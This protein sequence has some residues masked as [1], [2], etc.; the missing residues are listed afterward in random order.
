MS[1]TEP[2]EQV[3]NSDKRFR[4]LIAG[5]RFGKTHLAI[6]EL[7]K[8]ARIPDRE[9]VYIAPSYRQAK[10]IVWK[11]LKEKLGR[12][13]WIQKVNE[14][15]LTI[16][17]V[18]NSIIRLRS[19]DNYDSIRGMGI[20]MAVF[21]E[22]ADIAPET[23]TEVVRPAL[24]DREG[25]A[26]FIGT[27]KGISNWAKDLY[28]A[29]QMNKKDWASWQFTTIQGG[30]VKAEEIEAARQDLDDKTFRQEYEASFETYSGIIYYNFGPRVTT[31]ERPQL[32][33]KTE[34]HIGC[35]FNVDPMSAVIGV[36]TEKGMVVFDEIEIYGSNTQ[37]MCDEINARYGEY[38]RIAYPDAS[39]GYG[40]TTGTTDLRIMK[41]NGIDIRA[42][43]RNPAV[44][45]RINSVNAAF[46]NNRG[47]TRLWIHTECKRLINCLSKQI[48]KPDT[49]QPD[50]SSG[51]DHFPDALGY[52]IYTLLP[53]RV[54]R[55]PSKTPEYF[56]AF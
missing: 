2:Q 32:G 9:V 50:K 4:V 51:L 11:E 15:E 19:A 48:Y 37:E 33:K 21:D 8:F 29:G 16:Y 36:K 43:K 1:L 42:P 7:A 47:D 23:W 34:I 6:R 28:D 12:V 3:A 45:D 25:H 52:M 38:K 41:Q 46:K 18:N 26:L 49:Q 10:T 5:R 35:D 24:S 40:S 13:R 56:G 27:P 44:R 53:I 30:Q 54:E 17:L 31:T 20:D 55:T 39:G 22:F 14:S